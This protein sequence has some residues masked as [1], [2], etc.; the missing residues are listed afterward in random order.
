MSDKPLS[1]GEEII[2]ILK[3]LLNVAQRGNALT[4]VVQ[5]SLF[6]K[7]PSPLPEGNLVVEENIKE[8]NQPGLLIRIRELVHKIT[9]CNLT[10]NNQLETI[11]NRCNN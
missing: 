6:G 11:K 5:T 1:D 4:D 7:T 8:P 9:E 2:E 3:E 10:T